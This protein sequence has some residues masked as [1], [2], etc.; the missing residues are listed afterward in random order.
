MT[1]NDCYEILKEWGDDVR[2]EK[3]GGIMDMVEARWDEK[4]PREFLRSLK[5]D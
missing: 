3:L 4:V 2:L 5:L 1:Y